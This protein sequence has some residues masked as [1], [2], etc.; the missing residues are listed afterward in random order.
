MATDTDRET[1]KQKETDKLIAILRTPRGSPHFWA[2]LTISATYTRG[3]SS[4]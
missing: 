1:E 3:P 4:G 2:A